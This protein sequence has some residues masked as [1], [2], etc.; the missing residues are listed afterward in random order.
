VSEKL[1]C[2]ISFVAVLVLASGASALVVKSGETITYNTRTRIPDGNTVVQAGGTLIF[3]ARLDFNGG[4]EL[5]VYGT[6]ISKNTCKFPDNSGYQGVKAF[7]YNGGLWDAQDIENRAGGSV[8]SGG[9]RG[10]WIKLF[11]GSTLIV[12]TRYGD[13]H[14][15]YDSSFWIRDGSLLPGEDGGEINFEDLGGGAVQITGGQRPAMPYARSPEP[16][17][18][19]IHSDTWVNLTW[20]AGDFAVSH[21]VYLGDNFNDVNTGTGD[22]FRSNQIE[23]VYLVGLPGY[24]Y[25]DGLVAGTTYYWRID[26]VNTAESNSPWKGSVWSFSI[27]PR[28]A[29][30]PTPADGAGSISL[31]PK[32]TWTA[33][34]GAK[35]HTVYFGDDYDNVNNAT[36]GG[37]PLAATTYSPGSLKSAKVYYWRVDE[38]N[39]P[40]TYKGPVWSFT[41][42]GAVGNPYPANGARN[43]EM[44]VILTWAPGD[45][46]ASHQLYFGTDK[47]ALRKATTSSPDYK[48]TRVLGDESYDPGLLA[49][50]STYYWRVD[51]VNSTNPDSPWKGPVW[52]FTTDGSLIVDSFESYND[53]DP[54][55]PA[56]NR[57]FDK[58]IDGYANPTTNGA[59]VSNDLPPYAEPTIVHSGAQ[60]MP[61]RYDN[62]LKF[63]EAT[64][65]LSG[66][67]R[68]WTRQGVA[69]LSLWFRGAAANAAER[70]Y[71]ALNGTAVVYNT[72]PTAAQKATW[73]PWVIP[74]QQFA[75]QGVNLTNVTSITIGFGT[76]GNTT[77]AGGSGKMYFDDI[78]LYRSRST[79]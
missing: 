52:S 18:G 78:R 3:T 7:I 37:A 59:L 73:T 53:I 36:S 48:G 51:E 42:L 8:A 32:L 50:D 61:Y 43:A 19:A 71:I 39:P 13:G 63:S 75:D 40:N 33:G 41:T 16:S 21:D 58:W 66:T 4:D 22:T 35:L 28:T 44:N 26:E 46:A 79:P 54:P 62:N 77:T 15:F 25:P 38:T 17:D 45:E 20:K 31:N 55:D 67:S 60:S 27:P 57:I 65:T 76:R 49:W 29:Y 70:M 72:D 47:E 2:L 56:S 9:G 10:D 1:T 6:V 5:H 34:F 12:R 68:D 14:Q 64:M 24:A 30:N 23:N 74:L 11:P 69:S